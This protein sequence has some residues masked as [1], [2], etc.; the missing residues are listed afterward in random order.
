MTATALS[1]T[2]TLAERGAVVA[3]GLTVS[4]TVPDP[5]PPVA[6]GVT[7]GAAD[8]LQAHEASLAVTPTLNVSPPAGESC[9]EGAT[10]NA[11]TGAWV[12]AT[13]LSAT[14][15]LA[16][17][18]AVVAFGLTV[19]TTVPDP[20][21]PVADGVTQG[22]ADTLQAHEASLAVT[23]TL[24]VSPP[25]GES[26]DEGATVNAQ[27]GAWVTATALSATITLAE[28]GAVVAFGLTVSTTVP[29]PVPP[30][31][32][33]VTQGAADTL[34]A[35]EASLAVTATLN[36]SPPAGESCDEGARVNAQTGAWVTATALSA[37][38]TLAER[39]AVV[40]FGLTVSTTVPDPVP[41]VGDGVIQGA[42]DALQAHEASL[43]VTATLNVSPP[44]G[45]SCDEG[46]TENVHAGGVG[47]P[48]DNAVSS[49]STSAP[50]V[51]PPVPA[52]M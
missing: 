18:G 37:T 44:A 12:T 21:P 1:A 6:D 41:P 10:V 7:Q 3:F 5:V 30:V 23:P 46:A 43:A 14:I 25:A 31:G 17:R 47:G 32:D 50:G 29:D 27:T 13:A 8:T 28:R 49:A 19:S 26:C 20:V 36:V 40:A 2:I 33:G 24:K 38:I 9:D 4:T 35:H 22:A 51:V 11:Q 42:A 16:E 39:G 15:T 52:A 34:Q 45:E 48:P